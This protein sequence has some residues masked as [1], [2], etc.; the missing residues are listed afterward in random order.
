VM[1][2]VMMVV[3]VMVMI[4]LEGC[5]RDGSMVK[6]TGCSYRGPR[7][8]FRHSQQAAHPASSGL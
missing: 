6:S 1:V 7:V 4:N 5:C 2:M 3:V 8:S